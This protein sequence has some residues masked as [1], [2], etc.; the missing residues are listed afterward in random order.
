MSKIE[1][2]NISKSF[3]ELKVLDNISLSINKGDVYGILGL[4]WLDH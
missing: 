3:G 4:S 2:K 1:I